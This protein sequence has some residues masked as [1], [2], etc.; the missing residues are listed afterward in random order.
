MSQTSSSLLAPTNRPSVPPVPLLLFIPPFALNPLAQRLVQWE[1]TL[2]SGD[3]VGVRSKAWRGGEVGEEG[4][5]V[6]TPVTPCAAS[7]L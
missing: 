3:C 2:R 1:T 4:R 6:A 5:R 7:R